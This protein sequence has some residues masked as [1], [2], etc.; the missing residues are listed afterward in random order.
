V[1]DCVEVGAAAVRHDVDAAQRDGFEA[2]G[3]FDYVCV[4]HDGMVGTVVVE[5]F[6]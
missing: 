6:D 4:L 1:D 5:S 2:A 3:S